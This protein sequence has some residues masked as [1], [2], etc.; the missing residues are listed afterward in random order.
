MTIQELTNKYYFHDSGI[1]HIAYEKAKERLTF[2]IDLCY[3]AQKWYTE[4]DP[5]LMEIRLILDGIK[6][7]SGLVGDI[8]C[9]TILDAV[10]ENDKFR[11]NIRDDIHDKY[12]EYLFSPY[13][14]EVEIVRTFDD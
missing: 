7:Y 13:D 14:V 6:E 9:F 10:V 5:E 2:S 8:D 4:G 1:N 3:W 12:Y 11:M